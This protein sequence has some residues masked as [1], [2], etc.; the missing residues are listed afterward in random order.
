MVT[1]TLVFNSSSVTTASEPLTLAK[2]FDLSA[3]IEASVILDKLE[4]LD[5][6]DELPEE[7]LIQALRR[8][9]ILNS[10]VMR[11]DGRELVRSLLDL[12]ESLARLIDSDD[13]S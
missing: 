10:F 4:T 7:P 9:G 13:E 2:F 6:P 5:S 8:E 11:H 3:L 12:P 1:K